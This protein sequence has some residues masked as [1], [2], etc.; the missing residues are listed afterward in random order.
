[1]KGKKQIVTAIILAGGIGLGT[2]AVFAQVAPGPDKLDPPS[3]NHGQ[4]NRLYPG[5]RR[6]VFQKRIRCPGNQVRFRKEY[7]GQ[8]LEMQA[9]PQFRVKI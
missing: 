6:R 9:W 5:N 3:R 2:P 8:A 4:R 7:S 1:M